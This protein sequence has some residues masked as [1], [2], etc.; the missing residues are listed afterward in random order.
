MEYRF[1]KPLREKLDSILENAGFNLTT[2]KSDRGLLVYER[3]SSSKSIPDT[4]YIHGG[5]FDDCIFARATTEKAYVK[6][7]K[8]LLPDYQD[9]EPAMSDRWDYSN[10]DDLGLAIE[11][12]IVLIQS[13]LLNWFEHP[14]IAPWNIPSNDRLPEALEH[15]RK[16]V[17]D[18]TEAAR[19]CRAQ[20]DEKNALHYEK[21]AEKYREKIRRLGS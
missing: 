8:E 6:N 5:I 14:T 20:G 7:L 9:L 3:R 12:I 18:F 17:E 13:R 10:E 2:H 16:A 21:Q 19:L 1:V 11:Q 4:I 15:F